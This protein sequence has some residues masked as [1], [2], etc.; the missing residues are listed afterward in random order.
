MTQLLNGVSKRKNTK[1]NSVLYT[2]HIIVHSQHIVQLRISVL[3]FAQLD[4]LGLS[5]R[6]LPVVIVIQ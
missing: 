5:S 2:T 6:R 1:L 4:F 3:Q